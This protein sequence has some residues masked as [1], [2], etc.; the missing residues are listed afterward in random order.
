MPRTDRASR[1][2]AAPPDR[3]WAALV[4]REALMAWLPPAGMTGRFE[5]FDARPGGSYR[6]VLTYSDAS[7]AP[8]KAAVD[9]DIVEAR[10]VDI[11]PGAQVVQAVD[12]VSDDHAFAGTMTMTWKVTAVEAGTRVDIG[13][14]DVPD[15]I[16]AEDHAAGLASSLTNLAAY[17]EQ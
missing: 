5:R 4:D 16:S 6:M 13:A 3:V 11:V 10:F 14:E 1:V 8:G 12:F 17:V 7:A 9:S 15:G 2:I